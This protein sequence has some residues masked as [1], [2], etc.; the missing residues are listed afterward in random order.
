M[1][2]SIIDTSDVSF[3]TNFLWGSS[4]SNFQDSGVLCGNSNWSDWILSEDLQPI[5]NSTDHWNLYPEDFKKLRGMGLNSLR[6]SIEWSAIEPSE[7]EWNGAAIQHYHEYIDKLLE[8]KITPMVTM[9][10]FTHPRWFEDK[11]AFEHRE[12]IDHFVR[13]CDKIFTEFSS[14]VK[15]WCTINEPTIYVLQGYLRGVAPPGKCDIRL[16]AKVLRNL[17]QAHITI[18]RLLHTYNP[19]NAQIGLTHQHLIFQSRRDNCIGTRFCNYLSEVCTTTFLNFLS[20]GH[21]EFTSY[22]VMNVVFGGT[23]YAKSFKW[24]KPSFPKYTLTWDSDRIPTRDL[25]FIGLNYYSHVF[26]DI[27]KPWQVPSFLPNDVRTDMPY[28]LY[29]EGLADAIQAVSQLRTPIYITE[30]GIADVDDS[31]R[32]LYFKRYLYVLSQAIQEG[33]DVRGYF[34]W[35][36]LDNYEWDLGFSMR[37]GLINID[38]D[39]KRRSICPSTQY[40]QRVIRTKSNVDVI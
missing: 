37:F 19:H 2:W 17:C 39:T 10:H 12:N 24:L 31:R 5:G 11:G 23:R 18:Y 32:E 27:L 9:H 13:Y 16:A 35:S 34:Y 30:S 26:I 29:P 1:N 28:A 3:P 15:L 22:P 38:Y 33:Y 36:L 25:D 20:T 6:F 14:K 4:T 40:L 8:E 21:F 7:G